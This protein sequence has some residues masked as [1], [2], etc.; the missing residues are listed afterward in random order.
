MET[1]NPN[2]LLR[3]KVSLVN[4][5][6]EAKSTQKESG[7]QK[8]VHSQVTCDECG[9]SPIVGVRYKCTV[10]ND[11]DVCEA[12]EAKGNHPYPFVKITDPNH[13]PAVLF[14][15]F[16]NESNPNH[17]SPHPFPHPHPRPWGRC[18]RRPPHP[19]GPPHDG[20]PAPSPFPHF[21]PRH[22]IPPFSRWDRCRGGYQS[23]PSNPTSD[24]GSNSKTNPTT[25]QQD[26]KDVEDIYDESRVNPIMAA[27][28]AIA[29]SFGAVESKEDDSQQQQQQQTNGRNSNYRNYEL[30]KDKIH[31]MAS[32]IAEMATSYLENGRNP[33]EAAAAFLGQRD[34]KPALRFVR[35]VTCPDSTLVPPGVVFCKTWRVR[36]DGKSAWPEGAT[37]MHSS[38]DQLTFE[39]PVALDILPGPGEEIDITVHLK[40]IHSTRF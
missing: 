24:N 9:I 10:R 40:G 35:H 27:V 17:Q 3:F 22:G 12:C 15:A 33:L 31:K 26:D 37:L 1:V 38:G 25:E 39:D 7:S 14:Y 20:P 21:R 19:W 4:E 5:N 8:V 23:A 36:N 11:F 6:K 2:K 29:E 28:E 32:N 34:S 13:A 16:Q 18:G 30:P